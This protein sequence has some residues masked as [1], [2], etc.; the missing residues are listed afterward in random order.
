MQGGISS[1]N[2]ADMDEEETMDQ[3]IE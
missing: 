2:V 1:M 3:S